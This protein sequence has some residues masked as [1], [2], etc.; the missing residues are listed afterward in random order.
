[1]GV[2]PAECVV[3]EDSLNGLKAA[4]A[5][6]TYVVALTTSCTEQEVTPLADRVVDDFADFATD[7][8]LFSCVEA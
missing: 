6:G 3:F 4:R 2:E 7:L 5:A 1:M 8:T